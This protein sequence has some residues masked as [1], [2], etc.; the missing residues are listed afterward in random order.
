M[1]LAKTSQDW[2]CDDVHDKRLACSKGLCLHFVTLA[3]AR[4]NAFARRRI[5]LVANYGFKGR[6][7]T[8]IEQLIE[9]HQHELLEAWNEYFS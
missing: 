5:E 9:Q 2:P 4:C 7:L 6:E 3:R 1:H 8:K